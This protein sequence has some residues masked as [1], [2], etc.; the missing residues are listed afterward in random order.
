MKKYKVLKAVEQ[1]SW[2][3]G[4]IVNMDDVSASKLLESNIVE[5]YEGDEPH[6]HVAIT[7][8]PVKLSATANNI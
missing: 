5:V 6:K 3:I 1:R 4:D 8:D 2:E 7:V